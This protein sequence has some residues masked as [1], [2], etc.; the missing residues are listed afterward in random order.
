MNPTFPLVS[1]IVPVYNVERYIDKCLDTL[2]SQTYENIQYV[3]VNDCTPDDSVKHIYDKQN[4]Y[5]HRK[6][7][8]EVVS[9]EVN[10]GLTAARK[11]GLSFA[12]G[13]YIWHIDSDDYIPTNAVECLVNKALGENADMVVFDIDELY[14]SYTKHV[15]ISIPISKDEYLYQMIIRKARFE[16]CFRFCNKKVYNG[17][18][19]DESICYSEDYATSPRLVYNS[20]KVVHVDK[21]CYYY[22][23]NNTTSYTASVNTKSIKSL[24]NAIMVLDDFFMKKNYAYFKSILSLAKNYVRIHSM[25][26]S[27]FN[28]EAFQYSLSLFSKDLDYDKSQIELK[29]RV[30]LFLADHKMVT[31]LKLYIKIGLYVTYRKKHSILNDLL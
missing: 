21:V 10:R 3:F 4:Q 12:Q 5:S 8:V 6:Q 28:H 23:K 15:V 14:A 31:F 20:N 29:D 2:F 27:L 19:L 13:E 24:E 16:L 26:S 9:H 18:E 1:I 17:I 7:Q 25:K 30:I 11:T 22:F